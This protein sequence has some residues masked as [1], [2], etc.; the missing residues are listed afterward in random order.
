MNFP[1]NGLTFMINH[2]V[3]HEEHQP[4]P[5]EVVEHTPHVDLDEVKRVIEADTTRVIRIEG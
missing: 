2:L 3:D 5:T 4:K 1:V